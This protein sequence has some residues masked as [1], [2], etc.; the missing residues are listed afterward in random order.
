MRTDGYD[1]SIMFFICTFTNV[2]LWLHFNN[3]KNFTLKTW[4]ILVACKYAK[5]HYG[6]VM[7]ACLPFGFSICIFVLLNCWG[8]D[9]IWWRWFL[10]ARGPGGFNFI[11][12]HTPYLIT[13][14]IN[15]TSPLFMD[16]ISAFSIFLPTRSFFLETYPLWPGPMLSIRVFIPVRWTYPDHICRDGSLE[17][18]IPS[19]SMISFQ[20]TFSSSHRYHCSSRLTAQKFDSSFRFPIC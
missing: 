3:I 2:G 14:A 17:R 19:S 10:K 9:Q 12:L 7:S 1:W 4:A 5:T 6:R 20:N 15:F 13:S 8:L 18:G 11:P 16:S